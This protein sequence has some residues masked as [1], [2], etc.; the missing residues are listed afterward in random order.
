M[1]STQSFTSGLQAAH[2]L[3]GRSVRSTAWMVRPSTGFFGALA[4]G[5]TGTLKPS[6][7]TS[8]NCS[9][10][11]GVGRISPAR[12]T[13]PKAMKPRGS[14]LPRKNP[15]IASSTAKSA[16]DAHA[17]HRVYQRVQMSIVSIDLG[18]AQDWPRPRDRL[19][20]RSLR[21]EVLELG[22]SIAAL[23]RL[24]WSCA[25]RRALR[26]PRSLA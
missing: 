11:R 19:A 7:A 26:W 8:F 3:D 9:C 18:K 10:P 23:C 12:P 1:G 24:N 5:T 21:P 15:W 17:A 14:A 22:A 2:R 16:A 25:A 13:S 6:L 20:V 4:L